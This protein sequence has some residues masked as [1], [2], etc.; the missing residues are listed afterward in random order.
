M[1]EWRVAE[2]ET[3][4]SA[5]GAAGQHVVRARRGAD[6]VRCAGG[7][8]GAKG[9]LGAPGVAFSFGLISSCS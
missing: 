9:L 4:R 1:N 3:S 5:R 7:T 8:M 2:Q 6:K